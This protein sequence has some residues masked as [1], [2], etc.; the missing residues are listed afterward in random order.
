LPSEKG[1][2][3]LFDI[4]LRQLKIDEKVDWETLVKLTDGYSGADLANV[5]REASLMPFRKL[6]SEHSNMEDIVSRQSQIN[7]PLTMDYFTQALKNIS[8]SVST[9]FLHKY[10]KWMKDFGAT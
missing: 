4:N 6:L 7:I 9:E 1:R 10:Q 3:K 2:R 8:K 5:C